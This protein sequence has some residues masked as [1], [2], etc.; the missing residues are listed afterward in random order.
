MFTRSKYDAWTDA[1]KVALLFPLP[2]FPF[3]CAGIIITGYEGPKEVVLEFRCQRLKVNGPFLGCMEILQLSF[4]DLETPNFTNIPKVFL[5]IFIVLIYVP[6]SV[7]FRWLEC[8]FSSKQEN[9]VWVR[10]EERT[11]FPL[12]YTY[13]TPLAYRNW[14]DQTQ[15]K[16]TARI[17]KVLL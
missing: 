1:H 12:G 3:I 10:E 17:Q 6:T 13:R 15:H 2:Q 4:F 16:T 11:S 5:I 7:L 8:I 9:A 14:M